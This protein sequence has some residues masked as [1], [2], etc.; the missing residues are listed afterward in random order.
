M[1]TQI[2]AAFGIAAI[3]ATSLALAQGTPLNEHGM[4]HD[5]AAVRG[6]AT[7]TQ[8]KEGDPWIGSGYFIVKGHRYEGGWKLVGQDVLLGLSADAAAA[9]DSKAMV[10]RRSGYGI[11]TYTFTPDDVLY[12]REVNWGSVDLTGQSKRQYVYGATISG[13]PEVVPV[14]GSDNLPK[15]GTGLFENALYSIRFRGYADPVTLK[16][17]STV[18]QGVFTI[19][20]GVICNVDWKK[21]EEKLGK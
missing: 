10:G 21:L 3:G 6:G 14:L 19:E 15:W 7:A 12:A 18:R 4:R 8:A 2:V 16:D 13:P 20:D 1:R 5:C 11:E 17:G 9:V